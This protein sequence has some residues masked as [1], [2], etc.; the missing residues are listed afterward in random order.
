M[1]VS[2]LIKEL[3]SLQ[4]LH[5]DLNVVIADDDEMITKKITLI[6]HYPSSFKEPE[7]IDIHIGG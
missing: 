4:E 7:V 2:E 1:K 6:E 5:G 3:Q